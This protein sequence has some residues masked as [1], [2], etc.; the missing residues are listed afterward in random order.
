[1]AEIHRARGALLAIGWDHPR[2]AAPVLAGA[3]AWRELAG[4][5]VRWSFRS[6]GEFNDQPLEELARKY[7]LLVIDHPMIPE[8]VARG[9]LLPLE[10]LIDAAA[11]GAVLADAIGSNGAAYTYDGA[12]WALPLD[13]ACHVAAAHR[14]ASDQLGGWPASWEA[15]LT[16][17]R[18]CPGRV[19]IS[20][21][22]ADA[23]CALLTIAATSGREVGVEAEIAL[24][25]IEVL[26][27]LSPHLHPASWT[28]SPPALLDLMRD[29]GSILYMPLTFGYVTHAGERLRFLDPPAADG[30]PARPILGGAGLA[31]SASSEQREDAAAFALWL[32]EA[33]AQRDVVLAAGGQPASRTAWLAPV[34]DPYR[35]EFFSQTRASI[36]RAWVRP[37]HVR[38]AEF[39]RRAGAELAAALRDREPP[40]R[41]Q[42]R[43][44]ALSEHLLRPPLS[45]VRA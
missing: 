17:A 38:W 10:Q 35:R 42:R 24:E 21:L 45:T 22:P 40:E 23:L 43:L 11:L 33:G 26:A 29:G 39:H 7:D 9:V 32:C 8:V 19:A 14:D 36:E 16:A 34:A 1:V 27:E 20:L 30:R 12:T 41:I 44:G 28:R 2:C 37:K 13:A 31:V 5:Q 18:A 25:P 6:L 15:V 3:S 4:V